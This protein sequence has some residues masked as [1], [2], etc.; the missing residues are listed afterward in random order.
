QEKQKPDPQR[1]NGYHESQITGLEL[2]LY[3]PAPTYAALE[4]ALLADALQDSL[5]R[6]GASDP[7]VV[8]ALKG[9]KPSDVSHDAIAQTKLGDPAARK[10]L[11]ASGPAGLAAS[12]DPLVVLARDTDPFARRNQ[13]TL[14]NRVESVETP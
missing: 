4:E 5:E 1:L 10:A 13:E 3:S 14:D 9:R 6:L 12:T 7:F 8:A 11:V 2:N